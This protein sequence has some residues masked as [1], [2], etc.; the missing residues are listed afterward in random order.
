MVVG[1]VGVV[2]AGAGK[3]SEA[4]KINPGFD[5]AA[6]EATCAV[7]GLMVFEVFVT[8]YLGVFA[9]KVRLVK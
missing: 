6:D 1:A 5:L 7:A 3:R 2:A 4:A 8:S 9:A